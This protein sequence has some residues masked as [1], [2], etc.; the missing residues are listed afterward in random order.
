M[1]N[2]FSPR[3]RFSGLD[4]LDKPNFGSNPFGNPPMVKNLENL[5]A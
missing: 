3:H 5:I 2:R 1:V 4:V